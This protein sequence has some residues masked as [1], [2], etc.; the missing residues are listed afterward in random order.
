MS[1]GR[2]DLCSCGSGK[3]YKRCHGAL[4][5]MSVAADPN[6]ARAHALI[7]L[8]AT[9]DEALR[10]FAIE[11]YDIEWFRDALDGY[12]GDDAE[13]PDD[14]ELQL[15]IPWSFYHFP[16]GN[17][18]ES[19]AS[20]VL[21]ERGSQLPPELRELLV[22]QVEAW[23]SVWEVRE[24]RPG[25]G[26][27]L[28][29][30][31]TGEQRFVYDVAVTKDVV[32]R[33]GMLG[34]VVTCGDVS[35]LGGL[36]PQVL[37]PRETDRVVR[38]MKQFC[39]VRTK[40]VAKAK[41]RDL[42][43]QRGL[44]DGWWMAL[45]DRDSA[46]A[47]PVMQNTDG[48]LMMLTTDHFDF[49]ERNR[50]DVVAR[51]ASFP[52]SGQPEVARGETVITVTKPGNA[53]HASW[54]NTVVGTLVVKGTRL[55]AEANSM[56]RA[57]AL[58]VAIETHLGDLVAHRIRDE[59]S[60]AQLVSQTAVGVKAGATRSM[61]PELK[62]VARQMKESHMQSWVDEHIPAL[63]GLTPREAAASAKSRGELEL[64]LKE[65][66]HFEGKLPADERFDMNRVRTTLGMLD[67]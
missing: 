63:G 27:G 51:L 44:L 34:R 20:L 41:L 58:R 37:T 57:N 15:I 60:P 36:H 1:I 66:E 22:A 67:S 53:T 26:L 54:D 12:A 21:A 38:E 62:A 32:V 48:D 29:D 10:R 25:V 2:N 55:K 30:L 5:T 16:V 4:L 46:T 23:L 9:L 47:M 18:G 28:T 52:G 13:A 14:D 56:Q 35:L 65:F 39:R 7:R 49:A 43:F 42:N 31:L 11:N 3:K 59:S 17:D 8:D 50:R 24:V 6:V 45:Y 64:L 19:M 33:D 40:P 61:P